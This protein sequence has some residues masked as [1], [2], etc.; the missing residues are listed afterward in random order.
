MCDSGSLWI[1]KV[2]IIGEGSIGM[3]VDC[4]NMILAL[5][6]HARENMATLEVFCVV[7]EL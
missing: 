4:C 3:N 5:K 7:V 1:Y 2:N 6:L